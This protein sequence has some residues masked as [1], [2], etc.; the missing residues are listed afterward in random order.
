MT[1]NRG[2]KK[3]IL[4]FLFFLV[5]F[6]NHHKILCLPFAGFFTAYPFIGLSVCPLGWDQDAHEL[7]TLRSGSLKLQNL[8][9]LF[10]VRII[11][12]IWNFYKVLNFGYF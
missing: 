10:Y 7:E 9:S 12:E 8:E 2:L 6:G 11:F 3:I 4:I 1:E 5:F